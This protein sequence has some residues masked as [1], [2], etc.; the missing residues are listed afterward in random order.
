MTNK[1][2][3]LN[4]KIPSLCVVSEYTYTLYNIRHQEIK[5]NFLQRTGNKKIT[6]LGQN[7]YNLISTK[8]PSGI[9]FLHLRHVVEQRCYAIFSRTKWIFFFTYLFL[10][11]LLRSYM[12]ILYFPP[13]KYISNLLGIITKEHCLVTY[14]ITINAPQKAER[15][16]LAFEHTHLEK[17]CTTRCKKTRIISLYALCRFFHDKKLLSYLF[18]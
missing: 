7:E 10:S 8:N 4:D 13:K 9:E 2:I 1:T 6:T 5:P 18:I 12:T 16:V 17:L 15:T 11:C 3:L 14:V